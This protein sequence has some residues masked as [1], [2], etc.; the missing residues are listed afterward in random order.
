[1]SVIEQQTSPTKLIQDLNNQLGIRME[2]SKQ[3]IDGLFKIIGR[4]SDKKFQG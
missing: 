3:L 2:A 4:K 1:M